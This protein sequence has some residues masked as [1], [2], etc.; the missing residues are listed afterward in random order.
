MAVFERCCVCS[1]WK[2]EGGECPQCM[3]AIQAD[4][5]SAR[6]MQ[7]NDASSPVCDWTI[8]QRAELCR[9]QVR[10]LGE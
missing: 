3:L 9:A 4:P 6:Y 10:R 7:G 5:L 2:T 1:Y 8:E